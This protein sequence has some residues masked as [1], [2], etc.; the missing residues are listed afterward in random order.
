MHS[1]CRQ[2]G[3]IHPITVAQHT[4]RFSHAAHGGDQQPHGE[5]G[6]VLAVHIAGFQDHNAAL[7]GFFGIHQTGVVAQDANQFQVGQQ[8]H[9][10]A[11]QGQMLG[12]HQ[13]FDAR[14]H[15]GVANVLAVVHR[16]VLLQ[17]CGECGWQIGSHHNFDRIHSVSLCASAAVILGS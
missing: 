13:G 15:S 6:H 5:I 9:Q 7:Q 3:A 12:A 4:L 8:T 17:T 2:D 16:E 11:A 10:L 1:A 14:Q